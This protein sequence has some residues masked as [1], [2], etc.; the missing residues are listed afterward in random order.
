MGHKKNWVKKI[1]LFFGSTKILGKIF[2]WG[3]KNVLV[4]KLFVKKHFG[5]KK[6]F[7]VTHFLSQKNFGQK[8]VWFKKISVK[9]M[10]GSKKV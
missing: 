2:F 10:F 8:N 7:L 3:Q 9:K 5:S 4:K 1:W 6:T